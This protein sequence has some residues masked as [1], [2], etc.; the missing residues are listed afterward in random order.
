M[1]LLWANLML[2]GC[3]LVAIGG[4]GMDWIIPYISILIYTT[5]AAVTFGSIFVKNPFT[6]QYAYETVDKALWENPHFIQVNVVMTGVWGGIFLINLGLSGFI[7]F[8]PGVIGR[9]VQVITYFILAT[10]IIFTIT[11]PKHLRK[12]YTALQVQDTHEK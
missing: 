5:L 12:K 3:T 11:Y 1:I 4:L 10:G 8:T 2:F 7:L 9:M 6:L